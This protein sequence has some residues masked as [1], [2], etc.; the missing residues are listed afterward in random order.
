[1]LEFHAYAT[2]SSFFVVVNSG[3]HTGSHGCT[4]G[5]MLSQPLPSGRRGGHPEVYEQLKKGKLLTVEHE[6]SLGDL[7]NPCV[8][9]PSLPINHKP[10]H[11]IP[12][13]G[14]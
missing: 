3:I 13:A 2:V 9:H 12:M 7:K 6:S 1:M 11:L 8:S 10:D 14:G 5:T 4:A